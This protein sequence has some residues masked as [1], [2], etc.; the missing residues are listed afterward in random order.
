MSPSAFDLN[1]QRRDLVDQIIQDLHQRF[2]RP[3]DNPKRFICQK[4]LI[5]VWKYESRLFD[6]LGPR[7]IFLGDIRSAQKDFVAIL[8]ILVWIGATATLGMF[9]EILHTSGISDANL[10]LQEE[11]IRNLL[12]TERWLTNLFMDYQCTF[13]PA[14]IDCNPNRPVQVIAESHRLPFLSKPKWIGSGG[15]ASVD[16]VEIA[17]RY[18]K[19]KQ[20]AFFEN[21]YKVA[22]KRFEGSIQLQDFHTELANLQNFKNSLTSQAHIL[23]HLTTVAHGSDYY[24]LFDYAQHGDLFQFLSDGAGK[25]DFRE[26]FPGVTSLE[27]LKTHEALLYQC[28]ALTSALD[29]LHNHITIKTKIIRCA[30]MDLKP[31]NILI[32]NDAESIV[33]KWM[34]SDFGISV[35]QNDRRT[36][37]LSIRDLYHE[38]TINKPAF[39]D[40]GTYQPPE[41]IRVEGHG[42]D[43]EGA[44]R[45]SDVWSFGCVFSE[46][47]A[48]AIGREEEVLNFAEKRKVPGQN[49]SFWEEFTPNSLPPGEKKFRL[50]GSVTTWLNSIRFQRPLTNPVLTVW[51]QK[52]Q[53][54]ILIVEKNDRPEAETLSVIVRGLYEECVKLTRPDTQPRPHTQL[55]LNIQRGFDRHIGPDTQFAPDARPASELQA[56]LGTQS[57][58]CE[59]IQPPSPG[60]NAPEVVETPGPVLP[61]PIQKHNSKDILASAVSRSIIQDKVPVALLYKERIDL[62]QINISD[63]M[64]RHVRSI[65][66]ANRWGSGNAGVVIEGHYFAAWGDCKKKLRRTAYIGDA[67]AGDPRPMLPV[68]VDFISSVAVSPRG[69]FALVRDREIILQSGSPDYSTKYLT[70]GLELDQTFTHAVFNVKGDMLFA[71]AV[72]GK[73]ESLYAWKVD[74][75]TNP[76]P[77][78]VIHYSLAR[79]YQPTTIIPYNTRPG[80]IL[81]SQKRQGYL[82]VSLGGNDASL[83][84]IERVNEHIDISL[85]CVLGDEWLLGLTRTRPLHSNVHLERYTILHANGE[86]RLN[87]PSRRLYELPKKYGQPWSMQAYRKGECIVVVVLTEHNTCIITTNN[88]L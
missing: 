82:A 58:P 61:S 75:N 50:R 72:Y 29:W 59:Q 88:T 85:G 46:V 6:L 20:G 53:E 44:G 66:L 79:D 15:Y 67:T 7:P 23:Q 28:W 14:V 68:N 35:T 34:I 62:I 4:D 64:S 39:R 8:S 74:D 9:C 69:I 30:H 16:L 26:E 76:G 65:L 17:P 60:R 10:P 77:H 37:A 84:G 1:A 57:V 43:I 83:P 21:P 41:G 19:T 27:T 33:G 25:Y 55:G 42:T 38:V 49:D 32:M 71:W 47:L 86:D 24:I 36:H 54:K 45:R 31:D 5:E 87:H 52:V 12:S 51:A 40:L 78:H 2:V 18:L 22:C 11:D 56:A 81:A 80:C 13:C 48:W 70:T 73:Q 3:D 63:D